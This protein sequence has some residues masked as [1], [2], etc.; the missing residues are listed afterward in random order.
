MSAHGGARP[1]SSLRSLDGFERFVVLA[2]RLWCGGDSGRAALQAAFLSRSGARA[3]AG[4]A[5]LDSLME[6]LLTHG[7][8]P[9]LHHAVGC[10][11]VGADEALLAHFVTTAATGAR[12]DA[13]LMAMLMVDA[14]VA[15]LVAEAAQQFGLLQLTPG[16]AAPVTLH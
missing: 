12:E 15:P 14:E 11:C 1:V 6:L 2:L 16:A 8:R 10:D 3:A 5:R 9:F 7:R 4:L 13:L